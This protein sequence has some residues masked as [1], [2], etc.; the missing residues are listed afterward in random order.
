[1]ISTLENAPLAG[2]ISEVE[3][4]FSEKGILSRSPNFE[5]RPQQQQMAMAVART[6]QNNEHLLVEAGTGVGKSFGYLIPSILFAVANRK[7]AIVSTHTI[8]LQEQLIAKDL[9]LLEKILPV[10]FSY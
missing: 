6:L 4:I 7:K 2:L 8:N 3:E 9:P 10:K 5:Y 1:M